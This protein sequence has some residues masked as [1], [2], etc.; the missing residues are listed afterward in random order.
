MPALTP[1]FAAACRGEQK[2]ADSSRAA[3][4]TIATQTGPIPH[5][6]RSPARAPHH[7]AGH[8]NRFVQGNRGRE[9][10]VP[11]CSDAYSRCVLGHIDEVRGV[12]RGLHSYTLP[13]FIAV[14]IEAG[15]EEYLRWMEASLATSHEQ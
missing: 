3:G 1:R 2:N 7:A 13:E 12:V 10:A 6:W 11:K 4:D 15:S 9:T 5:E 14:A 8:G